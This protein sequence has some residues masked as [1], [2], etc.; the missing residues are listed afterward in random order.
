[1]AGIESTPGDA[2]DDPIIFFDG[3]CGMCNTFVNIALRLDKHGVFLFAPLQGE[4]ARRLLPAL[5][6]DPRNWSMIYLDERG[7]HDQS[8]ASLEVYRRLGG[9]W[10]ILSLARFVPRF[11]RN[12]A[13]RIIARNRYRWF[14]RRDTCRL[15]RPE[16]LKRFLP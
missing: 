14:G 16:E 12:W 13:Y 8:D 4:T 7:M 3:V 15:P 11:I 2:I 1:M 5:P 10:W 9:I 6:D